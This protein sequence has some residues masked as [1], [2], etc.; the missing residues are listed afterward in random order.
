M[1]T[2]PPNSCRI[3][4]PG[5]RGMW[6]TI[7]T[8]IGRSLTTVRG[9]GL[10]PESNRVTW[11]ANSSTRTCPSTSPIT[12]VARF[13]HCRAASGCP[14]HALEAPRSKPLRSGVVTSLG[15][16]GLDRS[17]D[18]DRYRSPTLKFCSASWS[19]TGCGISAEPASTGYLR[20]ASGS[21]FGFGSGR[22]VGRMKP[23]SLNC[24]MPSSRPRR[25]SPRRFQR[26]GGISTE[27]AFGTAPC[28]ARK[29]SAPSAFCADKAPFCGG[30]S[31]VTFISVSCSGSSALVSSGSIG[32]AA[33]C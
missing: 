10:L 29:V 5:T 24:C 14:R 8:V 28:V 2:G 9:I 4:T 20:S 19:I 27:V 1:E 13:T 12:P 25:S 22:A 11:P 26:R 6:N 18:E 21:V 7:F 33:N 16:T 17:S 31:A 15:G 23:A 32:R 3:S 30:E